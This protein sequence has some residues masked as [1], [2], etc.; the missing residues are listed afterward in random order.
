M[1]LRRLTADDLERVRQLR[2]ASRHAFF[3]SRE[4]SADEQRSWFDRLAHKPVAFYVIEEE[5]QVVGT[6][7]VSDTAKGRE[8]G[9]LVLDEAFRGRGLM[10]QA[11]EQLT[12][13][14]GIYYAEIKVDNDASHAVFRETG[15]VDNPQITEITQT[16][17]AVVIVH[18]R[19]D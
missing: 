4:I 7:S 14:P 3:D 11:V 9:N 13:A 8:I 16:D 1:R 15:F 6:I 10:R 19:V 18:K 2:N 17:K 12:A 5:A